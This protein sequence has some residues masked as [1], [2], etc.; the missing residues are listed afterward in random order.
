MKKTTLASCVVA[1]MTTFGLT[2]APS[3]TAT[4]VTPKNEQ[5]QAMRSDNLPNPLAEKHAK[6]RKDAVDK[7]VQGKATTQTVNGKRVI[8]VPG[9]DKH[10][11][12]K[13]RYV[14]YDTNRT[15]SILTFLVDFGD[16]TM[17]ATGGKAG[18]VHNSIPKPDRTMDG[19]PSDNNS[20]LWTSDFNKQ[21]YQD[22]MFGT[23]ESFKDFY[24]KLSN[25][26]FS[27]N[28]DV[29][30]WV[31]VPYNEARYGHNPV[32]GDGTSEAEMS[33]AFI[34][35]SA[36]AW[37]NKQKA[38]GKS[39]AEIV[40]YLK[41]FDKWDRYDHD[42]DGNFNEPDGYIDHFQA[43]HAGEGEEGGGGAEGEDA[44]WSHRWY[45]AGNQAGRQGPTGN[46]L[47]G[48]PLGNTGLWIGDYTTE[49]ENGGLGVFTHE[50]GHD[51]GLPDLYDT[52]NRATNSTSYW[53]LMS[54]G[55]WLGDG[56]EDIG[57][58]PGYMGP[59][60]KLQLGWIDVTTVPYGTNRKV[61]VG[62][63]D[64]D[65]AKLPQAMIVQ[66]PDKKTTT[67]YNTP[68]D[69][70]SQWWSGSA[71]DLNNTLTRSIDLTGKSSASV[72]AKLWYD[73]EEGYDFLYGEVSTDGGATW[74]QVGKEITG[75]RK[76]WGDAS[77]DLSGFA[78][79]KIDFR[80]RYATDGGVHNDGA[81]L[82]NITVTADGSQLF[83]DG[84]ENGDNGWSVKGFSR[85]SGSVTK[86][87]TQYYM[88]ENRQYNGYD[89]YLQTGPYNFG[90]LDKQPNRVEHLPFQTGMLVWLVDN[91]YEDNNVSAH[92]G[93][94][95]VLP[96]DS[97]P[98]AMK[99]A[100]GTLVSNKL[101][102]W[103]APFSQH[104][105]PQLTLHRNSA[106]TTFASQP[107]VETFNDSS[108]TAYYDA[109][110]KYGSTMTAGS[111]VTIKVTGATADRAGYDVTFTKK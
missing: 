50:F 18:P 17:S 32:D 76:S 88:A 34:A 5:S 40:A 97:H 23:G 89:R 100:D 14:Q 63:S 9:K 19:Q 68:F 24:S 30:D 78:G 39:D 48:V 95:L 110:N 35:D 22:L 82:D 12:Q 71:D 96:I 65:S 51:L 70:S 105:T 37:V 60:E 43:I 91:A 6:L 93:H 85:N 77:W 94:G 72:N 44:I 46:K 27:V 16:K 58:R 92:P 54:A 13:N 55:S 69:G 3:A 57:S 81:F 45:A 59:W 90:F 84:A 10:G 62:P 38:D 108:T 20:T 86:T 52:T 98:G 109:S 101:Q 73:I 99:Y 83:A 67:T 42:G 106:A 4:G 15:D 66:L 111:G 26:R 47:G 31:K 25:G 2:V 28:G 103:D 79:K 53:S 49:P 104:K 75:T 41:Q 36:T 64:R 74:Q 7:L 56:K 87:T 1:T 11:K 80:F 107:G 29:S 33:T 102:V 8:A 21:H 61:T